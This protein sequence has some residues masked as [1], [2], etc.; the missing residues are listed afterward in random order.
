[1]AT[2]QI[3][4]AS[5]DEN[6]FSSQSVDKFFKSMEKG[7]QQDLKLIKEFRK[8]TEDIKKNM[9][10]ALKAGGGSSAG[11][12][13]V[14][15]GAMPN[16]A[17]VGGLLAAGAAYGGTKMFMGMAPNTMAAVTQRMSAD[18]VAGI[19]GLNARQVILRSNARVGNG[20]T[21]AMGPTMAQMNML[22]GGGYT[23]TSLSSRNVMSQ[24]G[25]LSAITGGTNEQMAQGMA[26]INAMRFLR[27]GVQAR[28]SKGNLRP[29][30]QL[31]NETYRFLYGGRKI[32][33][34]QAAMVLNPGSKGYQTISMIAGGDSNLMSIL[35]M[36]IIARAKKDS[37]LSKKDLGNAQRSLDVMGVGKES[38]IRKLFNYNTSEARKLQATEKGL[39]G[40]YNTALSATTAVNNGFSSLAEA[41]DGLTQAFMGL[42]GFLQTL[43]GAGNTGATLAGM[44]SSI[45]GMGSAA[46][47]F[48][49]LRMMMGKSAVPAALTAGASRLAAGAG[50]SAVG[51]GATGAMFS[52]GSL[53]KR[54]GRAA[55]AA[56]AYY[57]M[58][59]LQGFLNKANVPSWLRRGGNVAF[60]ALQGGV[61]GGIAAGPYGA[62]AGSVV[63]TGAGVV[64]PYG[65]GGGDCAHGNI[66]SHNCG[67]MGGGQDNMVLQMPVPPG[68]RVTSGFGPRDNS[69]NP[70][71]SRNHTGIDYAVKVGTP[72]VAAGAG[73]VTETG[74]HRQYGNYVIIRHGSRSTLYAHL[75]KILVNKGEKVVAG[76]QI[77]LSGGKKGAQGAG[78]STGPHL[79]FEVRANGG[80]GAQGRKDPQGLFG[81]AFSFIK[82]KVTSGLNFLKR[83][84][85]RLFGTNFAYSDAGDDK[86]NFNA[87]KHDITKKTLGQ[88]NSASVS[89]IIAGL[90]FSPTS[91]SEL[92]KHINPNDPKFGKILNQN[93]DEGHGNEKGIY[94]GSRQ[95]L[96]QAL[97]AQGF[98]GKSLRTAFAVALAESGGRPS[99]IGD[100]D[101]QDKKWGPS[102]G[103]FQIRSLKNWQNHDGK[104]SSDPWRNAKKLRDP[105]FNIEA[106]WVKSSKGKKWEAW[107]AYNNGAFTKFLDDADRVATKA[108]IGGG[109]ETAG[110]FNMAHVAPT[111]TSH[112]PGARSVSSNSN[113]NIKVNMQVTLANSGPGEAQRLLR[114]FKEGIEKEL[115]IKGI[116]GY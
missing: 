82:G 66:G 29:P 73:V 51:A 64:N 45:M 96:M 58:E 3:F 17:V 84:S 50:L 47:Q 111:E 41:T 83:T 49:M 26:G 116:G 103:I 99:A 101:L 92:S 86:F 102:Y 39:V 76:Q 44:G 35:Q 31:I 90:N 100:V 107:S 74:L 23:A 7:L 28:D 12:G 24:L 54:G 37:P 32:T 93:Y 55:L 57:G 105:K 89:D 11:S 63:G 43:P 68:T 33:P 65:Q 115:E 85:N 25:G 95:A 42:K 88:Y 10:E 106:A 108:G 9:Q 27:I 22:Y 4:S 72:I 2:Q 67:G 109:P 19:S 91:Y 8:V 87:R 70:Q 36:G 6:P 53:L 113:V 48:G 14:G 77:A 46:L 38:P 34:E 20:A 59:K 79:H 61:T 112:S 13:K 81:K 21:S 110:G 52:K 104:G 30:N 1:M 75:S 97:H 18:T 94:G 98:R 62:L 56:G 5:D 40:G 114:T 80:V 60:D 78:T 16:K 15:L 69:K 71:I